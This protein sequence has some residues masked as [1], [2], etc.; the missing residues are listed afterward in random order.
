MLNPQNDPPT[1]T[2]MKPQCSP[3]VHKK[4]P[5]INHGLGHFQ[6]YSHWSA[7]NMPVTGKFV[8]V[9]PSMGAAGYDL[10][11]AEDC[12]IHTSGI[13]STGLIVEIPVGH[14]GKIEGHSSIA[15][16]DDIVAFGG[17]I[18]EDCRDIVKVKLFNHG[19]KGYQVHKGDR[20]AKLIIHRYC[21]PN[22]QQLLSVT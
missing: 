1:T 7:P 16:R 15:Y 3:I 9:R 4:L 8:P 6:A 12:L 14:Y 5:F 10:F 18:D 11:A 19:T 17:I 20:I 21:V 22:I 2:H 13:V